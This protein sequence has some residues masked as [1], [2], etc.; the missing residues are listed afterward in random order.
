MSAVFHALP[1]PWAEA[2]GTVISS[3]W[4]KPE[5]RTMSTGIFTILN[6]CG[7]LVGALIGPL[8]FAGVEGYES[9]LFRLK[10]FN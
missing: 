4:F 9:N 1:G 7:P 2:S 10:I 5:Y 3:R 8:V 6:A